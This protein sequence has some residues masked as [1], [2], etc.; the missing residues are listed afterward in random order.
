MNSTLRDILIALKPTIVKVVWVTL[1]VVLCI[2]AASYPL[3]HTTYPCF[4]GGTECWWNDKN[5]Y[6]F[7]ACGYEYRYSP[8]FAV[9]FTP[10]ASLPTWIGGM[11]WSILNVG[12]LWW[13]LEVLLTELFPVRWTGWRKT[14][15]YLLVALGVIRGMWASQ[16]NTLVFALVACGAAAV[17]RQHWWRAAALFALPVY[18]KIWPMAAAL[19]FVACW[20]RR[21]VGRFAIVMGVLALVPFLT[22]TPNVVLTHYREWF[23]ALLGPMQERHIYRDVWTIWETI[24]P[25]VDPFVYQVLQLVSAGLVLALCLWQKQTAISAK[26]HMTFLLGA[27]T[28]WQL[29]FGPGTE[30]N[31]ICLV[32]PM[33]A[34]ALITSFQERR[35]RLWMCAAFTLTTL[36]SFGIFERKLEDTIPLV[37]TAI[38]A[39]AALFA[40]WLVWHAARSQPATV[41]TVQPAP[42]KIAA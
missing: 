23:D 42:S 18:I 5:P 25:P 27:W 1:G 13:S 41:L 24:H 38:P 22:K 34:W 39:G 32:A 36:F 11:F 15:F 20:P 33:T 30:R 17:L 10:F 12:L 35:G 26:H 28:A 21:L 14:A 4:A 9:L 16:S 6:D 7:A 3:N 29:L 19:L 31:T 2:K 8:T 37:L 40:V